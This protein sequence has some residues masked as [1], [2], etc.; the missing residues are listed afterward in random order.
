MTEAGTKDPLFG[1]YGTSFKG[2]TGHS[3]YVT[4][5]PEGLLLLAQNATVKTQVFKVKDAPFYSTQCH[6]DLTAEEAV[7]RYEAFARLV[8]SIKASLAKDIAA[9]DTSCHDTTDL[10]SRFIELFVKQ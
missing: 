5:V 8:P 4:S 1:K 7:S 10:L 2:H 6:P 3:D 9:F